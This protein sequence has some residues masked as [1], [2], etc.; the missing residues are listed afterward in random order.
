MHDVLCTMPGVLSRTQRGFFHF[1]VHIS[2]ICKIDIEQ[3]VVG[4]MAFRAAEANRHY[5]SP[6]LFE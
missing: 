1:F 4:A 6:Y 2:Q 3:R 5:S